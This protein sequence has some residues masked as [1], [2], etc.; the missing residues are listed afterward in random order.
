M[1]QEI[2]DLYHD[3]ILREAMQLFEADADSAKFLRDSESHVYQ[4]ERDGTP[5]ILKITHTLR[6]TPAYLMGELEWLNYL[7]DNGLRTAHALPSVNGLFVEE[8]PAAQGHFLAMLYQKAP[9]RHVQKDEWHAPFF[10][11]WGAYIGRMHALTKE[12]RLGNPAWKRQ[13]WHEEEHLNL[14]ACGVPAEEES[15]HEQAQRLIDFT[16]TL[17]KD[18]D[19]YGLVHTDLH[20]ANF[21]LHE[22]DVIGFDFDDCGY[23]WFI[24][25]IAII[26]YSV[27]WFPAV[28]YDDKAAFIRHFFEHFMT[29]Y[30]RENQL[31]PSWYRHIPHFLKLRHVLIYGVLNQF[32]GSLSDQEAAELP[33]MRRE[34]EQGTEVV[35]LDFASVFEGK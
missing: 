8:I 17:P 18:R 33:R 25:D 29:G 26:L 2:L 27:Q 12:Y 5:Y 23:N 31:D 24:N 32:R 11:T 1:R 15:V 4:V 9:G 6:R 20:H 19:S 10:Q 30:N 34:I 22:G 14:R 28:P 13:E 21:Y 7:A 3:G 16:R 35:E